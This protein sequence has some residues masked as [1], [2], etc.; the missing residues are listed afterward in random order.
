MD[1]G[2]MDVVAQD[3]DALLIALDETRSRHVRGLEDDP[4]IE[5]TFLQHHRAAHKET[6]AALRLAGYEDLAGRVAALRAERS[7]AQHEERWRSEDARATGT[8]PRGPQPLAALELEIPRQQDPERRAAYAKAAAEAMGAAAAA[9]EGWAET[10]ARAA[11][12][13]GLAPDW[14]AVVEGDEVLAASDDGYRE[15]LAFT[16]RQAFGEAA[17]S[18][19]LV[20]ADL[21]RVLALTRWD[22]LF[23][24]GMLEIALRLTLERLGLDL[25]RIRID[26]G[27]HPATWPGVH[28]VGTRISFRPRGGAGDWQDLLAAAARALAAAS[29]RPSAR[30]PLLAEALAWLLGSVALEPRW[31]ADRVDVERRHARD[32]VRDLAL[33]RLFALRADAAALRVATEVER[34]LSGSAWRNA[35]RDALSQATG[36]TWDGVR[37]SRDSD[38]SRL[39]TA[40]RGAGAGER[41]RLEMRQRFDEDWW[42]NPRAAEHLAALLAAGALP[43]PVD[44][45]PPASAAARLL[46]ARLEG[47]RD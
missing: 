14:R 3:V 47:D 36:A 7:A 38:A 21:L 12:E 33:R 19:G 6:A 24:G 17:R 26:A 29:A 15:V 1:A 9:R 22:G 18:T 40:V 27:D 39:A 13:V 43:L 35:H 30:D 46:V 32:V 16:A 28:A 5:R 11:A 4:A 2:E 34:G 37:A 42:R 25:A 45:P 10:R 44:A 31:L 23:K 41:L 8:G 20:R